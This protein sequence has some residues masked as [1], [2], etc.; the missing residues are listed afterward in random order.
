MRERTLGS[1]DGVEHSEGLEGGLADEAGVASA[2][3]FARRIGVVAGMGKGVVDAE[4][5]AA[6]DDLGLSQM[7]QWRAD[8]DGAA[9]DT[10]FGGEAGEFLEGGDELG[11]TI[12]IA[13]VVDGVDAGVDGFRPEHFGVSE[14]EGEHD[15]VA[16]GDVSDG[17]VGHLRLVAI[18]RNRDVGGESGAADGVESD[19]DEHVITDAE[20][21]GD[22]LGGVNLGGVALAVKGG[23]GVRLRAVGVGD[24]ETGS[25]IETAGKKNDRLHAS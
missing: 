3:G 19:A 4:G 13:G 23:Q 14:G 12:G 8:L 10:G 1:E 9:F 21:L 25:G 5:E 7:D 17:D 2:A 16:G 20:G 18:F 15:G 24:G 22:A 6:L 11:T